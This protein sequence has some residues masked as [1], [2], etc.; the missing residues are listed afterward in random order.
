MIVIILRQKVAF[1]KYLFS[2]KP[3][4]F[5]TALCHLN[6]NKEISY[7]FTVNNIL[8]SWRITDFRINMCRF[9]YKCSPFFIFCGPLH[10][11]NRIQKFSVFAEKSTEPLD[12]SASKR[13]TCI[14]I[15]IDFVG[16]EKG[17][18]E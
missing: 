8:Y 14:A 15:P 12:T 13:Y 4:H 7:H 11:Q 16:F 6:Y 1:E 9:Y 17:M 5:I 10:D 18:A 2:K 3:A